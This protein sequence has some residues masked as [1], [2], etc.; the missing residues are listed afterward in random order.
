[1]QKQTQCWRVKESKEGKSLR[2]HPGIQKAAAMIREGRLVAFPTETVYGLGADATSGEAVTS[3]F[4]AK[5]RPSDNPLIV[6]IAGADQLDELV[7]EVPS[8]GKQLIRRFWP[9]PLT[10]ILR[11]RGTVAPPVTAG[12]DTLGVRVPSHPVAL[13][14]LREAQRPVAAPSANRSGKPSP[15]QAEHV[16]YDLS[17]RIDA[18]LDGGPTGVGVESTVVDV[19]REVPVLLRPGGVTLDMIRETV[20]EIRVDPGI[21]REGRAP[22]SPG[23]KYRHYAPRGELWV[24]GGSGKDQMQKVQA[25]ADQAR[26]EGRKV[27]ILTTDEHREAYRAEWVFSC[28][29][30]SEP[31]TVARGLYGCLRRFDEVGAEW[32]VAEAFPPTGVFFSVMNRLMKAAEGQVLSSGEERKA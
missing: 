18:L 3:I 10:V 4:Q 29:R 7:S 12:L 17:G 8:T 31:E 6:H 19:T 27:G 20:G 32:I 5:G 14:L 22:R 25:L 13:A 28:G 11:H 16:W 26:R 15:T 24:V 30:R 9:G 2:D 21:R 23:M 1:M